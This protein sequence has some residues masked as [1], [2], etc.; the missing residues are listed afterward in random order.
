MSFLFPPPDVANLLDL[1]LS[2]A[3]FNQPAP[4]SFVLV[5]PISV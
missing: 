1:D 4:G 2:H 3:V 5:L